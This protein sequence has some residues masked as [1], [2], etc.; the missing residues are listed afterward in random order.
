VIETIN[1]SAAL[2]WWQWYN[3]SVII[4]RPDQL[5][6]RR[7]RQHRRCCHGDSLLKPVTRMR[8]SCVS[9]QWHECI[10]S[11]ETQTDYTHR[12]RLTKTLSDTH[13]MTLRVTFVTQHL[14][15]YLFISAYYC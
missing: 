6:R 5:H 1:R 3:P 12:H 9:C 4:Y 10:S 7:S 13:T 15:S 14:N 11:A 2:I 8:I